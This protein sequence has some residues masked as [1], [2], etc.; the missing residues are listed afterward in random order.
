MGELLAP[1]LRLARDATGRLIGTSVLGLTPE[2][3]TRPLTCPD[4]HCVAPVV[5]VREYARTDETG[6]VTVSAHFRLAPAAEHISGCI[7]DPAQFAAAITALSGGAVRTSTGQLRLLLP[8]VF[9]ATT[10]EPARR[11]HRARRV[12]R[13]R[14]EARTDLTGVI[15][16]ATAIQQFLDRS[17][18]DEAALRLCH[19]DV[20]G[21]EIPWEEFCLGSNPTQLQELAKGLAEG[22]EPGHL[23]AIHGTVTGSGSARTGTTVYVE[24]DLHKKLESRGR[25]RWLYVRLRTQDP[26]LTEPLRLG[27]RF[28]AIGEWELF[29]PDVAR[30][31]ELVLWIRKPWQ[32]AAW[33]APISREG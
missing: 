11:N 5:P 10:K 30:A 27:R 31:A 18:E 22:R 23:I 21:R 16:S 2:L 12:D 8:T 3:F 7:Y 14:P 9:P 26:R 28:M 32:V 4:P 6:T 24:Q 29:D 33:D 13:S 15:K 20:G 1:R 19:V 17:P 25:R